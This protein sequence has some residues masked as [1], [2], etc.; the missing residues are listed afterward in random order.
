MES[1][2]VAPNARAMAQA[3]KRRVSRVVQAD[4]FFRLE[5]LATIL[6]EYRRAI[7]A[8]RRYEELKVHRE[9]TVRRHDIPR[10]IFEEFY[11]RTDGAQ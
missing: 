11:A 3:W 2:C 4:F 1:R 8:A 6:A 7:T 5:L 10:R 9:S